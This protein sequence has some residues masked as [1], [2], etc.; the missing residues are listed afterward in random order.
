MFSSP[1]QNEIGQLASAQSLLSAWNVWGLGPK[2]ARGTAKGVFCEPEDSKRCFGKKISV[3]D[4]N[5]TG[6]GWWWL[7]GTAEKRLR[8]QIEN[9]APARAI[10]YLCSSGVQQHPTLKLF[11]FRPHWFIYSVFQ[12]P[13]LWWQSLDVDWS[14]L[15]LWL[16]IRYEYGSKPTI[17]I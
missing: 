5:V 2:E 6:P 7:H 13:D 16:K 11:R 9:S 4:D 8:F 1:T 12:N 14:S 3:G 17:T 15:Q 10:F